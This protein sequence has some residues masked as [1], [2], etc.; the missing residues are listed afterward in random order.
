MVGSWELVEPRG[1]AVSGAVW[2]A[3]QGDTLATLR[4]LPPSLGKDPLRRARFIERANA[5]LE[6]PHD[7]IL[8]IDEADEDFG[9]LYTVTKDMQGGALAALRRQRLEPLG[10]PSMCGPWWQR[11]S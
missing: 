9:W 10:A 7:S 11:W 1:I 8:R 4:L 5:G 2:L 3:R 6:P